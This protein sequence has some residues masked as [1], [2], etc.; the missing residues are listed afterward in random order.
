MGHDV[1]MGDFNV[2][3]PG[4]RISGEVSIGDYNLIG[5]DSFVKQQ[6][7]IGRH[8][9]LSPL[10]ALLTKPKDGNV[11]IGNFAKLFKF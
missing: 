10:S 1:S 9:T 4:A 8:V 6:I 11:Y 2:L 5:A 7:R 3:M